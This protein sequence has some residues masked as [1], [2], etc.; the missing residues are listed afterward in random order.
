MPEE[1]EAGLEPG[2]HLRPAVEN[3]RE[4]AECL[5]QVHALAR[6]RCSG[7]VYVQE[8]VTEL[9]Q[10]TEAL[11]A[12]HLVRAEVPVRRDWEV[13]RVPGHLLVEPRQKRRRCVAA[14]DLRDQWARRIVLGDVMDE[15]CQKASGSNT[16]TTQLGSVAKKL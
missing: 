9:I 1:L 3:G 5:P 14:I 4:E 6:D 8:P 12:E 13:G 7:L 16:E 10:L 11:L 15:R 2:L